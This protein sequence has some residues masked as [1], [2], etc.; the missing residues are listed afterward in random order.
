MSC[1]R[2]GDDVPLKR[3]IRYL[4]GFPSVG[5]RF[6]FQAEPATFQIYSDSDWG[7]CVATRRSCSGGALRRGSHLVHFW[8]RMQHKVAA[9]SGE[10]ELYSSNLALGELAGALHVQQEAYGAAWGS[11][12]LELC[13]DAS[14]CRSALYRRGCGGIKHVA[15]K[16]LWGQELVRT[17]GV[18]V[19][20]VP[21]LENPADALASPCTGG[22]LRRLLGLLNVEFPDRRAQSRRDERALTVER[23]SRI[24][25]FPRPAC[26]EYF[27]PAGP[28]DH[29]GFTS[30]LPT[31]GASYTSGGRAVLAEG[32]VGIHPCPQCKPWPTFPCQCGRH[33][34]V[35]N[36]LIPRHPLPNCLTLS[37][38]LPFRS[39]HLPVPCASHHRVQMV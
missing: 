6:D 19:V 27:G 14:A 17:L 11:S 31:F 3:A 15:L 5:L 30:V 7:S 23:I 2:V 4:R 33:W 29:H 36:C 13:V 39:R 22:E 1:P 37:H 28:G 24:S 35:A 25:R 38:P 10:A 12:G 8:T 9:S 18:N 32:G 16:D 34:I 20:R 26:A 21:R